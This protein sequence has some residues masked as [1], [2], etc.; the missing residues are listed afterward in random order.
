MKITFSCESCSSEFTVDG[1]LAGR[2]GRCKKCGARFVIPSASAGT[3]DGPKLKFASISTGVVE[4]RQSSVVS[5]KRSAS[6]SD[7]QIRFRE[8]DSFI[9]RLTSTFKL[10]PTSDEPPRLAQPKFA[11]NSPR[12]ASPQRAAGW[13]DAVN[14]QIAL[15]PVSLENLGSLRRAK[16][17][18]SD[19]ISYRPSDSELQQLRRKQKSAKDGLV[20]QSY[21]QTFRKAAKL[22]RWI[23]ETAY[24]ISILF[25]ILAIV[26]YVMQLTTD[27][28][29]AAG[30]RATRNTRSAE[31]STSTLGAK[32]L[33]LPNH[34]LIT[35][36]VSGIVILNLVR[37]VAGLANLIAIPFRKSPIEGI[38]FLIPPMTF[39][40]IWQHWKRMEKPVGRILGP[41][42][43]L[44]LV[45][46]A[47]TLIAMYGKGRHSRGDIVK[48]VDSAVKSIKKDVG[49]S[50][51]QLQNKV[52]TLQNQL[53]SQIDSARKAVQG[54][55]DQVQ[56][57][58]E[59][60]PEP[61]QHDSDKKN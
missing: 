4:R 53:P 31:T 15:K 34:R 42:F 46:V 55:Q 14:S 10:K 33:P 6:V 2:S 23:N 59:G 3:N 5:E 30:G 22:F 20:R 45:V 19:S 9:D 60:R 8:P 32:A 27:S 1:Q 7:N 58:T 48:D 36:G 54:L 24:G 56:Q 18:E 16:E 44:G 61:D 47:Y 52:E 25:M 43:A 40:Y 21:D 49:S 50:V 57:A 12:T 17:I 39:L 51:E 41:A 13:L 11:G 26:G 38:L 28:G 37:L 35:I 29:S